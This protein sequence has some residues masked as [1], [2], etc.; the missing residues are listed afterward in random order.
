HVAYLYA[1]FGHTAF[2]EPTVRSGFELARKISA[3][4][5]FHHQIVSVFGDEVVVDGWNR[6]MLETCKQLRFALKVLY[7]FSAL[8]LVGEH[9]HHLFDCA[10]GIGQALIARFVN[11][12]HAPAAHALFDQVTSNQQSA[13]LKLSVRILVLRHTLLGKSLFAAPSTVQVMNC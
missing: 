7:G 8:T 6:W 5:E 1:P 11:I 12:A 3:S 10:Q 13:R 4:D 2:V 9:F